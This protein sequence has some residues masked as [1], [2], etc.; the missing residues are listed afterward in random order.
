MRI[1]SIVA[2]VAATAMGSGVAIAK[3]K[4]D[5]PGEKKVCRVEMPAVGRIPAKK[6]CRTKAEWELVSAEGQRDAARTVGNAS[7]RN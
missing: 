7:G 3:E 6:V 5:A 4:S 2:V 1:I